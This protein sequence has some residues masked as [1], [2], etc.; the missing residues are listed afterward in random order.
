MD[1]KGPKK[2]QSCYW[3]Q[4]G[5]APGK[6]VDPMLKNYFRIAYRN[7]LRNR[8]YVLIN[9]LGLGIALAC[10]ITSYLLVAY[11][12][13]FDDFHS[14][15]KV[16]N[17]YKMHAHFAERE[18]GN[19][20]QQMMVPYTLGPSAAHDI[21][22]IEK[23][24]RYISWGGYMRNGDKAFGEGI[25]F[26]DSTFFSMFDFPLK[27]GQYNAFKD[28]YSIF[29]TEE[30]AKKYFGEDDP[31]GKTLILNF[32][33]DKEVPV[34]VG[35]V[36]AKIPVNNTFYFGAIMRIENFFEI[37]NLD[38]NF[39]GDWRCPTTFVSVAEGTDPA[40]VSKQLAKYVPVRNEAQKEAVVKEYRLEHFMAQF[41]DED[42]RGSYVNLRMS[43]VPLLVFVSMAV[44]ILLIACFNLTNTSI[45]LT[46]K[47]LKEVGVR[48]AIGAARSQI[49][50]QFLL[51]TVITI[52]LS[53]IVGLVFAQ[54]L[55][56]AFT[57]MWNLPYGINELNG[58][59][60]FI[61]LVMLV[62]LASLLA[63]I[64]PALFQSGFK[65]VALLK[66]RVRI[67]GTNALTRSLVGLQ[68]AISVIVLVGGVM[69]VQNMKF[70]EQ[71][72]FGYDKDNVIVVDIQNPNEYE[73]MRN[74]L[75]RNPKV[76]NIAPSCHHVSFD[77]YESPVIIDT[78]KYQSRLMGVGRNYCEAMGFR[79]LQGRS[80][81]MD[82]QS[83]VQEGLVV[84]KAFV[85][86]VGLT[87]PLD[88]VVTVH[89]VKRRIIGVI[90]NHIDNL[91]RSKD[92]EPFVLYGAL[93]EQYKIFLVKVSSASDLGDVKKLAEK[94][95]KELFPSKPFQSQF[96]GEALM[97]NLKRVN[98]NLQKIFLF[99][100]VLGGVLS[101]SGIYSLASLN[102]AKRTKEIGIR[103]ALGASVG[104]VLMLLNR[105]FVIILSIAAV[106]GGAA[107]FY[108]TKM[109]MDEI[110]AYH[111][112]VTFFPIVLCGLSVFTVGM[113]TT[114]STILR[115][116]RSNPV[117]S[118]RT[119]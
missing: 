33:N 107:G 56:P 69:F 20:Y 14:E 38:P 22:G 10:C 31:V 39:W 28:K 27:A 46:S 102:I 41:N 108:L 76:T 80:F 17:V 34:I 4:F 48:K 116:A 58:V 19:T 98:G 57:E 8:S 106:L 45:A 103:K 60:L 59:N 99:L 101:A 100:T 75:E 3:Y 90:D 78:T 83:D 35:G 61:A 49:L 50:S 112:P 84:N 105:E 110:Y 66:G 79:F 87:D 11:N 6:N 92:P 67:E 68:F 81:N 63:G 88:K 37:N 95:W 65:P 29:L 53:L 15:K 73:A 94:T 47:R 5:Y 24:C 54:F 64:Y 118:L 96:Q 26:V 52:T 114:C 40:H 111:I 30:I 42:L 55:V 43:I 91:Y 115:A 18:T 86:K 97:S 2:R 93:P 13:E 62:F 117:D 82:N 32:A 77:N 44:M 74:V 70:Q 25:N 1:K 12:I 89:G 51:E 72:N 7:L 16:K 9:T 104:N 21:A 113:L 36:I 71:V 119:E 23:Y 109:L 85:E